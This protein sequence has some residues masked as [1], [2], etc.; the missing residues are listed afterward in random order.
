MM[1]LD[2]NCIILVSAILLTNACGKIGDI[3]EAVWGQE[4][5]EE[6]VRISPEV[7]YELP[8]TIYAMSANVY[9]GRYAVCPLETQ[10]YSAVLYDLQEGRVVNQFMHYG[11]GPSEV[12][13]PN[14]Y[15][16][17]DTLCVRDIAKN[18]FYTIPCED[19][20]DVNIHERKV[21]FMSADILP[22]NGQLLALN[23]Y[24][25]EN[26]EMGISNGE[27]MLFVSDGSEVPYDKSKVFSLNV[28]QG[29][30]MHSYAEGKVVFADMCEPS[31]VFFDSSLK[32]VKRISG[33]EDYELK[34]ID[35]QGE[36]AYLG[37]IGYSYSS[38]SCDDRYVYLLYYG[39]I[40]EDD[41]DW[42]FSESDA[43]LFQLDWDGN[44]VGSYQLEGV[45]S[46]YD[47]VS[48]GAEPGTVDVSTIYPDRPN[49]QILHFDLNKAA[50]EK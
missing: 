14:F 32:P 9:K 33:P 12:L 49:L 11:N 36:L 47:V 42:E 46:Y 24:Y 30:L 22:Y 23:P 2:Y 38:A 20:P 8:D 48:A 27:E 25:W 41:E 40:I 43:Y 21:E 6:A 39:T 15:I 44:L 7:S 19:F 10:K 31:V 16:N 35:V 4:V 1:R 26:E 5:K 17:G 37:D 3:E 18:R 13:L 28:V 29:S 34:Y 45:S 50:A